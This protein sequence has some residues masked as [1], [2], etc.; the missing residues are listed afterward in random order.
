VTGR[1]ELDHDLLLRLRQLLDDC[2]PGH[3][4]RLAFELDLHA[5][6]LEELGERRG[7]QQAAGADARKRLRD[8]DDEERL[9]HRDRLEL[10]TA[11]GRLTPVAAQEEQRDIWLEGQ[12]SRTA[13]RGRRLHEQDQARLAKDEAQAQAERW[14][15]E[16]NQARNDARSW[17]DEIGLL[18]HFAVEVEAPDGVTLE[19]LRA[20]YRT[21]RDQYEQRT[22][23]SQVAME[24]R[25][26]SDRAGDVRGR[27]RLYVDVVDR[28]R[29]L[30][31]V[32][33]AESPGSRAERLAR[34]RDDQEEATRGRVRAEEAQ[35]HA[36]ERLRTLSADTRNLTTLPDELR[37]ADRAE[38][39][40]LFEQVSARMAQE[41]ARRDDADQAQ[42]AATAQ[43]K[44]ASHE[45]ELLRSEERHLAQTLAEQGVESQATYDRITAAAAKRDVERIVGALHGAAH[46]V[47]E[48]EDRIRVT[49]TRLRQFAGRSEYDELEGPYRE[50]L[51]DPD[52]RAL[53]GRAEGDL[54]EFER[55][56]PFLEHQLAEIEKHQSRVT[57]QLL[58]LVDDALQNLRWLQRQ[59][60][61]EGLGQWSGQ[62]YFQIRFD[63]PETHEERR[64]RVHVLL[65]EVVSAR[66]RLVGSA[67]VQQ[68]LRR[69]NRR[70]HFDVNVLK[71]NE[72]LRLERAGVAEIGAWSGGQKLTTAILIYCAL[73]RLRADNRSQQRSSPVG[74]LLLDNPIGTA[75]LSTL[76]D[77]QRLVAEKFGVQLIYTT[78]IDDKPALAPFTNVIRLGNRR[79]RRRERDHIVQEPEDGEA[80]RVE[81][82]RVFRRGGEMG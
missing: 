13:E 78:G 61:P 45:H 15:G 49:A 43:A 24:A 7:A 70:Q 1:R 29:E 48:Q 55:R 64:L 37:P 40:R 59:Q 17:L 36:E 8:L 16:A 79:E 57:D 51:T 50:R 71:P 14:N 20:E 10:A 28:A 32:P 58:V 27:L 4:E 65:D 69:V 53:A 42:R 75:N 2:P 34:A 21:L 25:A 72:G 74:V 19:V 41:R 63:L 54:V 39:E 12:A 31:T 38:A 52:D 5:R 81:A 26:A 35:K 23:G 9:L 67:L 46:A 3:L 66:R 73:A 56:R 62:H 80:M 18:P 22:T 44:D 77:L 76:I 33:G 82:A 6:E 60:L 68:A 11:I 47:A 30:L